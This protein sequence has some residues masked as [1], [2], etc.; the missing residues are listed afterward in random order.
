MR[1]AQSHIQKS[2]THSLLTV[3]TRNAPLLLTAGKVGNVFAAAP[4]PWLTEG[5]MEAAW[6]H[7]VM[8]THS[9]LM[10]LGAAPACGCRCSTCH[11]LGG[12]IGA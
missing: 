5:A 2:Q 12:T 9:T 6:L 8:T 4:Q 3:P 1:D 7:L 11:A 10:T